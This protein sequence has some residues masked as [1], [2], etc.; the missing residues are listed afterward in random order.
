V[1]AFNVTLAKRQVVHELAR[2]AQ[3]LNRPDGHLLGADVAGGEGHAGDMF[4]LWLRIRE[5]GLKG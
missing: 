3:L 2:D 5:L 1:A 4:M